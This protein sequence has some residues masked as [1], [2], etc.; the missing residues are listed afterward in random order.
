MAHDRGHDG[1][2]RLAR[3]QAR[4]RLPVVGDLRRA[5]LVV[6]LRPLRRPAQGE[7]Q[8]ALAR[9]DGAGA[10]RHRR[11]RLGDHPPPEGLGGIRARHRASPTRSSTAAR[12][13]SASAPTT[14]PRSSAGASAEQAPRR[15][16]GLRPDR[17]APVQPHVRDPRRAGR[18]DRA[19][20]VPPP[21][22]RP[23]DLPQ[24][25]ER[26]PARA[27]QAAVRD[28]A[29]RQVVPQRDHPRELHLPHARVRAD[30][31]GV[32]RAACRGGRVVPLL[33]RP[34]GRVVRPLRDPA[35]GPSGARARGRRALALLERDER[36]RV[37]LPDRLVGARG[38]REPRARST[39]RRTRRRPG[40]RWNGSTAAAGS[41][42]SRR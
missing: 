35:G 14:S 18:G 26:R 33:D 39:S 29:G 11:A 2:D 25:Q 5:R 8:G 7:R 30:G 28:R 31:D 19:A 40:R 37:P 9:G 1:Q 27:A 36:H 4:V 24:L 34:A 42:T 38:D 6:R 22:D 32:L 10:R 3:A 23:G 20:G 15:D 41:G 16:A 17:G 12:A 13:R 21:G